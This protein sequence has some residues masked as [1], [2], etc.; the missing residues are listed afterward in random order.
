MNFTSRMPSG[1]NEIY[2]STF[3]VFIV[4]FLFVVK[5]IHTVSR[6]KMNVKI[7]LLICFVLLSII[8]QHN[9]VVLSFFQYIILF[10]ID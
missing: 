7:D 3:N 10:I 1:F 4:D 2:C 8:R 6:L 5:S 9:N